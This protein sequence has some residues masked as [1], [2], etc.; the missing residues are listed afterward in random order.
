LP[1]PFKEYPVIIVPIT[2][3][4]YIVLSDHI[5]NIDI[6]ILQVIDNKDWP[7][8]ARNWV[9]LAKSRPYFNYK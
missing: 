9:V 8:Y 2:V 6:S 7:E 1:P 3:I 4:A 5:I